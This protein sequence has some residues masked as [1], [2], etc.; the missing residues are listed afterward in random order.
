[1]AGPESSD[2]F[3]DL[4]YELFQREGTWWVQLILG[5]SSDERSDMIEFSLATVDERI[6]KL[7]LQHLLTNRHSFSISITGADLVSVKFGCMTH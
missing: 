3:L 1:M 2:N 6:A 7:R 5:G 4:A